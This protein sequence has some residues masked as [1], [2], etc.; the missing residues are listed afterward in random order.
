MEEAMSSV[1]IIAAFEANQKLRNKYDAYLDEAKKLG[2][3]KAP[4]VGAQYS[5]DM[6]IMYCSYALA[7]YYGIKLLLQGD[8][9]GV[10]QIV[11]YVSVPDL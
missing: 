8:V 7:W 9:P 6:F 1:R 10:G 2:F 11:T 5:V 4:I 3:K